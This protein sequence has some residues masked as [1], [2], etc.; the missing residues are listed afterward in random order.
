MDLRKALQELADKI[1][2]EVLRRMES[3]RGV[4]PRTGENTLKDSKL[5]KSVEV[6]VVSEDTLAF[7]IADY[8]TYVV[9]GRR[10]GWGTPPPTG[11]VQGVTNWVRERGIRFNGKTENQTIWAIIKSIV[12]RGIQGRAILG[13]G[14]ENDDPSYVLPFLDDF[15]DEWSDK[16][17][18]DIISELNKYFNAA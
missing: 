3:Y 8:Y 6:K 14:Y 2:E 11:F 13:N 15:F 16:V 1:K 12:K 7:Q 10:P 9:G 18:E 4:N 5:Y 17:F